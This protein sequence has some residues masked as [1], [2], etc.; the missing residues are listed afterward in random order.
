M[1]IDTLGFQ[2]VWLLWPYQ[3]IVPSLFMVIEQVRGKPVFWHSGVPLLPVQEICP[4][5]AQVAPSEVVVPGTRQAPPT[6]QGTASELVGTSTVPVASGDGPSTGDAEVSTVSASRTLW[7]TVSDGLPPSDDESGFA[8][9][10]SGADSP[11]LKATSD[12]GEGKSTDPGLSR[13][14]SGMPASAFG[15]GTLS[16]TPTM[17]PSAI[18]AVS[19]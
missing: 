19:R 3:A 5:V 4:F 13:L 11:S 8:D 10:E 16:A 14:E 12:G 17:L 18:A 15:D 1:D 6:T 9:V 2:Y 7:S